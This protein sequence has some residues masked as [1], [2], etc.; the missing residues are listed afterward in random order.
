MFASGLFDQYK[1]EVAQIIEKGVKCTNLALKSSAI[2]CLGNFVAILEPSE[3]K[4]YDQLSLPLL[5][6]TLE[7]VLKDEDEGQDCLEVIDDICENEPAFFKKNLTHLFD[8]MYSIFSNKKI[9]SAGIKKIACESLISYI[10]R[11][12]NSVSQ[13][14]LKNVLEMIFV[15]MIDIDEEITNE[16][17]HPPEGFEDNIEDVNKII[18]MK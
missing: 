9:E 18:S 7:I 16:W 12:P 4:K 15:Q 11:L 10:Y 5:Q 14:Q 1:N 2:T 6:S 13:Q 3:L 8:T 17:N